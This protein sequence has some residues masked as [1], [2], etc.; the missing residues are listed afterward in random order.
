MPEIF[1][2][3]LVDA[4][5]PGTRLTVE[6]LVCYLE[7]WIDRT[8]PK[9]PYEDNVQQRVAKHIHQVLD[10]VI[11]FWSTMPWRVPRGCTFASYA[12]SQLM[13]RFKSIQQKKSINSHKKIVTTIL[14]DNVLF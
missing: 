1:A 12:N 7:L 10:P 11:T 8:I 13:P 3:V 14:T 5:E 4:Q 9:Y 6:Q 2:S